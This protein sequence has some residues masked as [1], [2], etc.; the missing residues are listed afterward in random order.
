MI[1]EPCTNF[2][3]V[4]SLLLLYVYFPQLQHVQAIGGKALHI[5]LHQPYHHIIPQWHYRRICYDHPV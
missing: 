1:L 5:R 4:L 2:R 3:T